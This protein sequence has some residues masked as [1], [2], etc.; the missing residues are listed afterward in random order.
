MWGHRKEISS[1]VAASTVKR[2]SRS[3]ANIP[4]G[5]PFRTLSFLIIPAPWRTKERVPSPLS[6]GAVVF[7]VSEFWKTIDFPLA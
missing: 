5:G 6:I 7:S 3:P 2:M 4:N 1:S